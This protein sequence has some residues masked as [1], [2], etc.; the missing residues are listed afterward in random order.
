MTRTKKRNPARK[1]VSAAKQAHR[2]VKQGLAL[3]R[4]ASEII[5]ARTASSDPWEWAR[6]GPEK[7]LAFGSA[8]VMWMHSLAQINAQLLGVGSKEVVR[9]PGRITSISRASSPVALAFALGNDAYAFWTRAMS[10]GLA[11]GTNVMRA[12]HAANVPIARAVAGNRRR[13]N[14]RP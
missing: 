14:A 12:Q 11:I 3:S 13:L 10:Q 5:A 7:A 4:G 6:C 1:M 8:G 2:N 9:A